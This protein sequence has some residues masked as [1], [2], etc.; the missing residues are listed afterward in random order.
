MIASFKKKQKNDLRERIFSSKITKFVFLIVILTFILVDIKIYKDKKKFDSKM[1]LFKERTEEIKKENKNLRRQIEKTDDQD[2]IEKIAREE[3]D[4]QREGE[5]IVNFI[6]P[7]S[8]KAQDSAEKNF[9]NF[10]NWME[11]I[12]QK[13][14][15]V[16]NSF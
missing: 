14:Q 16:K 4:L 8:K 3:L 11:W 12:S 10:G 7:E 6:M 15:W 2:Y 1:S 5:K 9:F 13:W